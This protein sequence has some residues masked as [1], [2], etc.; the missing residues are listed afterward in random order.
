MVRILGHSVI[1]NRYKVYIED[2]LSDA[3][4][5]Y[6]QTYTMFDFVV[7]IKICPIIYNMVHFKI[8]CIM[9]G[10]ILKSHMQ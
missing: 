5:S 10:Y 1:I 8:S 4:E 3:V 2:I 6:N 7:E 9:I